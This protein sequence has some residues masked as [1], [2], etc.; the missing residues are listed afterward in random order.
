MFQWTNQKSILLFFK[1]NIGSGER[2]RIEPYNSSVTTWSTDAYCSPS[3]PPSEEEFH[4]LVKEGISIVIIKHFLLFVLTN[5]KWILYIS[6]WLHREG[7]RGQTMVSRAPEGVLYL[8]PQWWLYCDVRSFLWP[9][10]LS[11]LDNYD[12]WLFKVLNS[13]SLQSYVEQRFFDVQF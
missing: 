6:V 4:T 1:D 2:L 13:T 7:V 5:I 10:R 11:R 3:S 12:F 8:H 9:L